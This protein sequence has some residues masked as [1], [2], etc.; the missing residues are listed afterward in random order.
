MASASFVITFAEVLLKSSWGGSPNL[1]SA[2]SVLP[3]IQAA[4]IATTLLLAIPVKTHA[5]KLDMPMAGSTQQFAVWG[6]SLA[7]LGMILAIVLVCLAI[8]RILAAAL[9]GNYGRNG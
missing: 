8:T 6:S 4:Y 9:A 7:A 2:P 1:N 3:R 5:V